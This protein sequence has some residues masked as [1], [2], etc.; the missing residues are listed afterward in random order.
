MS[1]PEQVIQCDVVIIS[2]ECESDRVLTTAVTPATDRGNDMAEQSTASRGRAT[3][4]SAATF[5]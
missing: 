5:V 1:E 2:A 4:R 3:C